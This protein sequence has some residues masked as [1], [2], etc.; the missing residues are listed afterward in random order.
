MFSF[1]K[2]FWKTKRKTVALKSL[3]LPNKIDEL[4]QIESVFPKN[5]VTDLIIDK[6]KEIVQLQNN[7]KLDD[8]EH[9][10]KEGTRYNFSRYFYLLLFF[11]RYTPGKLIITRR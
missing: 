6:L 8:L 9:T 10:A 11:D 1:R 4:K 5:Q 3:N 7:I 2:N